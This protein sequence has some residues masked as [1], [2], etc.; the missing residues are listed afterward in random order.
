LS[1]LGSL[2]RLGVEEGMSI[3]NLNSAAL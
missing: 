3:R 2:Q 1:P